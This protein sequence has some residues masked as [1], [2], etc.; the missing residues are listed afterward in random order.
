MLRRVRGEKK[1]VPTSSLL[2]LLFRCVEIITMW[3]FF[4]SLILVYTTAYMFRYCCTKALKIMCEMKKLKRN[5]KKS[6]LLERVENGTINKFILK[7]Y[8]KWNKIE[9]S[10][11]WNHL[12]LSDTSHS[13]PHFSHPIPSTF[14][15]KISKRVEKKKKLYRETFKNVMQ[16]NKTASQSISSAA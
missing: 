11:I 15:T 8:G 4:S 6:V 3:F 16:N 10:W 5:L 9:T 12:F 14:L 1:L 7:Q 13:K 2:F